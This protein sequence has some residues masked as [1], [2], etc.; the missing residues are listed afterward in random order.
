MTMRHQMIKG[1]AAVAVAAALAGAAVAATTDPPAPPP[2]AVPHEHDAGQIGAADSAQVALLGVLRR[3]AEPS[4]A[5]S[6]SAR[7]HVAAGATPDL[8]AN[9]SLARR[10]LTTSLGEE[11]YVVPARGWVCLTSSTATGV[12]SPTDRI[13]EG[14]A[15][16]LEQIPSGFRLSGLVPDGVASVEVR[17]AGGATATS[18][19]SDNAWRADVGFLPTAVAWTGSAGEK[20]VPVTVPAAPA[21]G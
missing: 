10:A 8:G 20:V 17:G 12:C 9:A 7:T 21:E 2:P 6:G 11:L 4:D 14:Y 16:G 3:G 15:V 13:A 5:L 18:E 19:V 1:A